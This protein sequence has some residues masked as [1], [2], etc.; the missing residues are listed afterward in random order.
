[1]FGFRSLVGSN[2]QDSSGAVQIEPADTI[3][4]WEWTSEL[5]HLLT[6][7][8]AEAGRRQIHGVGYKLVS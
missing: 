8:R 3:W 2:L 4:I 6:T 1:M 7:C 5:K